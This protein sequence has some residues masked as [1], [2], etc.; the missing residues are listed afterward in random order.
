M[1][2]EASFPYFLHLHIHRWGLAVA[3]ESDELWPGLGRLCLHES[4]GCPPGEH[5]M[6]VLAMTRLVLTPFLSEDSIPFDF[7]QCSSS[8][9]SSPVCAATTEP[10]GSC[11]LVGSSQLI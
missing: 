10:P 8:S 2:R 6:V 5:I 4:G 7:L 11:L 3:S 1:S 9:S